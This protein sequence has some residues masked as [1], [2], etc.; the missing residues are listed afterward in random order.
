MRHICN[1][2][3]VWLNACQYRIIAK[4]YPFVAT[5][6]SAFPTPQL[7]SKVLAAY[8]LAQ[9]WISGV[10]RPQQ[11]YS[12][13]GTSENR[14][15]YARFVPGYDDRLLLTISKTIWSAMFLWYM[16]DQEA[17][18][19]AHWSPRGG[20]FTG[21]TVNGEVGSKATLAISLQLDGYVTT[22]VLSF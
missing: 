1:L 3:I 19:V 20:I 11:T 22:P 18:M 2:R 10:H 16:S 15:S 21:Y 4:G 5:P 13:D 17:T 14:V 7:R 8:F 9:R 12:I 6:L